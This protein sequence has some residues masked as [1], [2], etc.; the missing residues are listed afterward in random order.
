MSSKSY[1]IAD[2]LEVK[3]SFGGRLSFDSTRLLF[4]SNLP[5]T[6]QIFLMD[7]DGSKQTQLTQFEDFVASA[8]F[9]PTEN[10]IAFS[11]AVG[12]NEK[13]QLYLL[14]PDT[15][16]VDALTDK[17]E[18]KHMLGPFSY[19][20]K[21]LA[22][23]SLE[24]NNEDFDVYILDLETRKERCVF[25]L[26]GVCFA[27]SFSPDGKYL[28]VGRHYANDNSDLYLCN[29]ETGGVECITEHTGAVRFE[30]VRWL[31]DS[32]AIFVVSDQGSEFLDLFK[33]SLQEKLFTPALSLNW[34]ID[35]LA[36]SR[37]GQ[38][39]AVVSNEEGFSKLK[40][41]NSNSLQVLPF[42]LPE[43]NTSDVSFSVDGKFLTFS[44]GDSCTST[45]V[46]IL[47]LATGISQKL[48]S[49][50]QGVPPEVLVYP[51]LMHY[52]SFDGLEVPA[53]IYKPKDVSMGKKLPT[54]INIHGGPEG[55]ATSGLALITQYFVYAGFVVVAPNVRGS[56]GYG[57]T[58]MNLDNVEKRMDSVKD[59]VALK[60]ELESIQEVDASKLVL[61]GGSYGGFMVLACMVFFPALWVAGVDI[62]GIANFV[63][64]LQ[65]TAPYRRKHREAEYG[66]LEEDY[67][68]LKTIS[69]INHISNI[70]AP[71]MVIHG[72]NDPR[73]PLSEAQ[74][75]AR[76]LKEQGREVEL[77]VYQDEGHGL[78]KLK[79]R[80]DAYPKVVEFLKKVLAS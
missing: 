50:P 20:G 74:Q 4:L 71:L 46:Y 38:Y 41:Y 59:I 76:K 77:L 75:V 54:I 10:K 3:S 67:E 39:L 14:D 40:I 53:F 56:A 65:N 32:Q 35:S 27:T 13:N 73:V 43:G 61:M 19:D 5:G 58:Y 31:P 7:R 1:T 68:F 23:S 22:Y 30:T 25:S 36:I 11:K 55:Q 69:P 37:N 16:E 12:G 34:D 79:N 28:V 26:G 48:T 15:K 66:S 18:V 44:M 8:N 51:E 29:L 6:T 33:Y 80:L 2:F 78:G 21:L 47:D 72:A 49:S 17:P 70:Q 45:N 52:K 57:K 60:S 63:T 9:S 42:D 64:F 62:V 24:R